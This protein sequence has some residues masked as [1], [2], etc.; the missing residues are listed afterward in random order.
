MAHAMGHR[1]SPAAGGL[2]QAA[3]NRAGLKSGAM[4]RH[5]G[6]GDTGHI[7]GGGGRPSN[8]AILAVGVYGRDA[9]ATAPPLQFW[10]A[11]HFNSSQVLAVEL[12]DHGFAEA[13]FSAEL[14][15]FVTWA[16]P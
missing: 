2:W 16:T 6:S 3:P 14:V 5:N 4:A 13:D 8:T 11:L 9:R 12:E 10:Q 15:Q 1:M 7:M